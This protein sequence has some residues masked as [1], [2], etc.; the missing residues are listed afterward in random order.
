MNEQR[1]IS[2]K[3]W[4]ET[5]PEPIKYCIIDD[6]A[7]LDEGTGKC[8]TDKFCPYRLANNICRRHTQKPTGETRVVMASEPKQGVTIDDC[9]NNGQQ[10]YRNGVC[11]AE[12]ACRFKTVLTF[13]VSS[14]PSRKYSKCLKYY[15]TAMCASGKKFMFHNGV[16]L[17]TGF[18]ECQ[19]QWKEIT[20]AVGEEG[21]RELAYCCKFNKFE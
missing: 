20:T 8:I 19:Y 3:D 18:L 10:F 15:P 6:K 7:F 13:R 12:P 9:A 16:C 1:R 11:I 2:I 14:D 17:A 4:L 5:A 21:N